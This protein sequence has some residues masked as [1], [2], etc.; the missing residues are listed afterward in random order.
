[1]KRQ[2]LFSAIVHHACRSKKY[3]PISAVFT[4]LLVAGIVVPASS[5]WAAPVTITTF[6]YIIHDDGNSPLGDLTDDVE[7]DGGALKNLNSDPVIHANR[8]I[9]LTSNGGYLTAGW[10]KVLTIAGPIVGSAGGDLFINND[11]GVVQLK[12]SESSYDGNTIIGA[13]G[14][15]SYGSSGPRL[16]LGAS[17]VLPNGTTVSFNDNGSLDLNGMT[18]TVHAVIASGTGYNGN[19]AITNSSAAVGSL[20]VTGAIT[21]NVFTVGGLG[22]MTINGSVNGNNLLTKVDDNTL[23]LGGTADNS[24]LRVTVEGGVLELAKIGSSGSPHIHALGG[25]IHTVNSGG[26]LQLKGTGDDQIH[27]DSTVNVNTG[28]T[29]DF[30]GHNEAWGGLGGAGTVTND[31]VQSATMTL[32]ENDSSSQFAGTIQDGSGGIS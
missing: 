14:P 27:D 16:R 29:F 17:E 11:S 12:N 23:T 6:V 28:G 21:N 25:G 26:T 32:G 5:S 22:D 31:S 10:G 1:M 9:S 7:L 13:T 18:E 3:Q 19:G 8:H 24:A 2:H 30:N 20:I 4:C 15:A